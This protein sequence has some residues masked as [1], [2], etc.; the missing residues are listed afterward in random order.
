MPV[1]VEAISAIIRVQAI[2]ERYG[3]GWASF[4]LRVP[5]Q[6]LCS[7]NELARIGFMSPDD[8]KAFVDHLDCVG[9]AFLRNGQAQDVTVADQL[10]GFTV[11]CEWADFERIELNPGQAVSAAQLKGTTSRQVFC[12]EG[13]N[14]EGSLSQQFGFVP[15]GQEQKSL[16]F[17]RHDEGLDVYLNILT[18]NEVYIGRTGTPFP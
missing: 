14:Y 12:P 3:G 5:N 18:G 17:L 9:I 16:R 4:A 7:D 11:P 2:H 8:C 13:W 1:L 15:R 6:T 10:R